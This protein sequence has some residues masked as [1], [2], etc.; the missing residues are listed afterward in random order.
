[1]R[2]YKHALPIVADHDWSYIDD[3]MH[4]VLGRNAYHL[5]YLEEA[6]SFFLRLLQQSKQSAE[7]QAGFMREATSV[8]KLFLSHGEHKEMPCEVCKLPT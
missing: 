5:G 7:R 2:C 3:H 1:M 6:V 4:S 8:I